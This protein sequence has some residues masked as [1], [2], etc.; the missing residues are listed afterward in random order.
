[1]TSLNFEHLRS[2]WPQFAE[3]GGFGK[4]HI[5]NDVSCSVSKKRTFVKKLVCGLGWI[6][7]TAS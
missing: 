6:R 1:V 7:A 2:T 5:Y 3:L 4:M